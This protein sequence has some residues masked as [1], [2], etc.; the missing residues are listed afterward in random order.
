MVLRPTIVDDV[1]DDTLDQ[2]DI[3]THMGFSDDNTNESASS[4]VLTGEFLRKIL[5]V[6][7]KD[8]DALT[9]E[10]DAIIGLTEANGETLQKFGVFTD[11]AGNTLKLSRLLAIAVAKTSDKEVNVGYKISIEVVDQTG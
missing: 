8:V 10:W 1:G 9:Y 2:F 6:T 11:I 5:T 4:D 7:D 3:I